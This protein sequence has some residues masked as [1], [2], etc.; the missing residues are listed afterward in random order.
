M[1][2]RFTIRDL[3]WLTLV[4]ALSLGWWQY[5][6]R[7][8][9]TIQGL[10]QQLPPEDS[11]MP[12][13]K[14]TDEDIDQLF[15]YAD[16][17]GEDLKSDCNKMYSDD[18]EALGRVFRFSLQFGDLGRNC[19]AYGQIIYSSFLNLGEAWGVE[20]YANVL[21]SQPADVQQRV[22]DFICFETS[23]LPKDTRTEGM[24]DPKRAY[25]SMFPPNYEFGK[26]DPLFTK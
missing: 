21:K 2:L 16:R 19:R 9:D 4:V 5:A 26:D 24:A 20:K 3:L 13:G 25:P 1:R 22:R 18:S 6:L 11:G 8:N 23:K 12:F 10:R 7:T 17:K 14:I 15:A